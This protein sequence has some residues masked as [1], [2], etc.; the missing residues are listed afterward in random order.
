MLKRVLE[1]M[2]RKNNGFSVQLFMYSE[3]KK[4]WKN[5]LFE[6]VSLI[7]SFLRVFQVILSV[8]NNCSALARS[9]F[10]SFE[11]SPDLKLKSKLWGYAV[12]L[13]FQLLNRVNIFSVNDFSSFPTLLATS[14]S[15]NRHNSINSLFI[16]RTCSVF[17]VV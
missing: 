2:Y 10:S 8:F 7:E 17:C 4:Q 13:N 15:R 11:D 1:K 6:I 3:K 14:C 16:L 5:T 9:Q 12:L